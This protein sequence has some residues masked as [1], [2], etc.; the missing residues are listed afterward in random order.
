MCRIPY[1]KCVCFIFLVILAILSCSGFRIDNLAMT[2]ISKKNSVV[3]S[4]GELF[5][6][7]VPAHRI[8]HHRQ[9]KAH[10]AGGG[11]HRL[12]TPPPPSRV[13]SR[14]ARGRRPCHEHDPSWRAYRANTVVIAR[15]ES[16][17]SN[18]KENYTVLFKVLERI[19]NSSFPVDDHVRLKFSS[20]TKKCEHLDP[21]RSSS[22]LLV[23]AKI[24][25]SKEYI[26][27][28][29]AYGAHNYTAVFAPEPCR[30]KTLTLVRKVT[31]PSFSKSD[32]ML[33]ISRRYLIRLSSIYTNTPLLIKVLSTSLQKN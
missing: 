11:V 10:P 3:R 30:N 12:Q 16:M 21:N 27:F 22:H 2:D 32:Q 29:D 18:R 13:L 7:A 19:K 24:D 26:L 31:S 25:K 1:E 9:L 4:S 20:D 23:K 17:S 14:R 6:L 15:A 33:S 28:L 8:R 5:R